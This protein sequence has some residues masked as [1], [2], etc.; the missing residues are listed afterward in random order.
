MSSNG[1]LQILDL[2]IISPPRLMPVGRFARPRVR[3]VVARSTGVWT[4]FTE[5][6][7]RRDARLIGGWVLAKGLLIGLRWRTEDGVSLDSVTSTRIQTPD[8]GRRLLT[9]LRWPLPE[10]AAFT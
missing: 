4:L 2:K 6:G 10:P 8:V 1:F 5:D 9:R 7:K 3:R